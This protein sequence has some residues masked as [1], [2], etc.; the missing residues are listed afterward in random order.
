MS[1]RIEFKFR[2][3]LKDY[4]LDVAT[5]I[6]ARGITA[7]FGR[8]GSGKTSL[9]RCMA[10]LEKAESAFL[11]IG[12]ECWHDSDKT[13][14]LAPHRRAIG[15][16]FQE[17]ALFPHLRVRGNLEYGLRRSRGK[18]QLEQFRHMVGLLQLEEL[19]ERFPW[20]LSGGEK[21]RVALGRALLNN[22]RLLLMDEPLAA[23]DRG[24]KR[25]ILPYIERL[26]SES[27][28][29]IIYVTHDL[30]EL[31]RIADQLIL[32]DRGKI[33]AQGKLEE[34][35][36]RVDLPIAREADAG[37]VVD[38]RILAHDEKYHLSR[39]GFS[40]GEL[41][42]GWIDRPAGS[43]VR[44]RIH[45]KDV[46]LA[47]EKPVNSSILNVLPA[48]VSD[49]AVHGRGRIVVRL[50]VAGSPLLARITRKSQDRLG[51]QTGQQVYALIKSVAL[52]L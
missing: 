10:G 47:L 25:E 46:S 33:L 7:L 12:E 43:R 20:Q 40:G 32:I 13:I 8:S 14:F 11:S 21:Q 35:L 29:P 19:L 6:P 31:V 34:I 41:T 45:A 49:M 26:H 23:L 48:R 22:P 36:S 51:L 42:V 37:A 28:I 16:V 9:L 24:R 27:R 30:E 17:G 50:D 18:N 3:P 52:T 38:A 2:L 1:S 44:I 15:Y 4:T 5:T 39:L